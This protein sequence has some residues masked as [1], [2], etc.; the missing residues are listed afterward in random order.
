MQQTF[1]IN[2]G[3]LNANFIESV[4]AMFGN[5][6]IK[7]VIEDV[8]QAG[9]VSQKELYKKSLPVIERFKNVKVDPKLDLSALAN[10][11]NL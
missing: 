1:Q 5:R 3:K 7:I 8:D 10:E 4:R 11:V 9:P 2:T 6:E